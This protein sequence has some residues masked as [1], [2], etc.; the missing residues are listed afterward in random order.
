MFLRFGA[1]DEHLTKIR[2]SVLKITKGWD[3]DEVRT[4]VAETINE[5]IEPLIYSEALSSSTT[6]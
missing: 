1:D 3:H 5:I 4:L 6:T 2:E